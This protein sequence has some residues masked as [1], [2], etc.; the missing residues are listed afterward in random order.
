MEGEVL[1]VEKKD[2]TKK[3]CLPKEHGKIGIRCRSKDKKRTCYFAIMSQNIGT[4]STTT[5][6]WETEKLVSDITKTPNRGI[7]KAWYHNVNTRVPKIDPLINRQAPAPSVALG[8]LLF[9]CPFLSESRAHQKF[10]AAVVTRRMNYLENVRSDMTLLSAHNLNILSFD[11]V[12]ILR[13]CVRSS[14]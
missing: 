2:N 6:N 7:R 10:L 9:L 13:D 4:R 8:P 1:S 3:G 5:W 12:Q 14:D 11:C